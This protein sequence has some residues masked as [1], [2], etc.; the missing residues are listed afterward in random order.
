MAIS[1]SAI[2]FENVQFS[3]GFHPPQR[4]RSA[5]RL[6]YDKFGIRCHLVDAA[7]NLLEL[8]VVGQVT[9][10]NNDE[11]PTWPKHFVGV[12]EHRP[13]GF[14]AEGTIVVERRVD[15]DEVDASWLCD[16]HQTMLMMKRNRLRRSYRPRLPSS[17]KGQGRVVNRAYV[18]VDSEPVEERRDGESDDAVTTTKVNNVQRF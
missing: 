8:G 1:L 2:R 7:E 9:V 11:P 13:C 16:V 18:M 4:R 3:E 12:N 6:N 15:D 10:A 14:I 5:H 17:S